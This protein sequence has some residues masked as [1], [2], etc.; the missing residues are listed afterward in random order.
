[1]K[2]HY[3]Q[4]VVASLLLFSLMAITAHSQNK[5]QNNFSKAEIIFDKDGYSPVEIRFSEDAV[6]IKETFFSQYKTFFGLSE[7]YEF[8]QVQELTDKL[9]QTHYRFSQ[10]YKGV[11]V[12][13]AQLILHEKNGVI[14]YINGQTVHRINLSVYP[15]IS[16]Q[17]ALQSA[18]NHIDA[19]I[20][21]WEIPENEIFIKKEQQDPNATFYPSGELKITSGSED[22]NGNNM[23]LV[24][25]FDIYAEQPL[26]RN[27]VDVNAV[28][29][30]VIN[31]INRIHDAD[32]PGT[33]TSLYNGTVS[34]IVD[35]FSGG[36]RLQESGRG[37]GIK[38]YDMQNGY[39]YNNATDFV[40]SDTNFT[41]PNDH[42]GVSVHWAA[43]GTYDYYLNTFGRNSFNNTG[44]TILSYAHFGVD[45]N[46]A[47]WDGTRL[48]FGD[49]DG[50]ILS[51]VVAVDVVGHE[52][53]HGVTQYSSNLIYSSESGALN[54]SFSDIFGT[55]VEFY[56][57]GVSSADWIIGEDVVLQYPFCV[58]S[59]EN[60]NLTLCPD[61]YKGTYWDFYEEVHINSGVQNFWFYLLSVGGT[62]V[63]DN[64]D[65]YSVT[66]IGIDD[67]AEIAY[68]NLT[69]YLTP[70]S[71]YGNAR[72]GSINAAADL[73]GLGSL[74]Y[75]SVIDAWDA[76]GVYSVMADF[77]ANVTGGQPPM[78]VQFT[79]L[80]IASPSTIT[81]WQWDFNEDGIIDATVQ[82]PSWTYTE[83]G[84]Y[85]VSLTVS[86]G[87]S[88]NT[89]TKVDYVIPF[90]AGD[91]LVWE[92]VPDGANYSGAF[93]RDYLMSNNMN[94]IYLTSP[95]IPSPLTGL[96]TVFL[97]FGNAGPGGSL[98][99]QFSDRNAEAIKAYLQIS[100]SRVY[101]EGGVA[102]GL[103]QVSNTVL[104]NLLGLSGAT[105]GSANNTPI[106][107]LSGQTETLTEGMLFTSSNQPN[108]N[109]IDKY[110]PNALGK[111]AFIETTVGNVAVQNEGAYGQKSFCFSY[112]LA[113]LNDSS[114]PN[115]R[116]DL[117]IKILNFFDITVPVE[118]TS[119]T[120]SSSNGN[121]TLNW[122]TA[123]E[124]NNLMFE[125]ER[126]SKD[127]QFITI[128]YVEGK[129][130]TTE[131]QEY[132]Y[133]DKELPAGKYN[134]R[135]KQI[136]FN[137]T[138]EYSNEIEVDA[139]PVSFS[140]E[141]NYPN[142]FNPSTKISY[143][144]PQKSFVTLKVYDQLGSEVAELVQEE[145][146][147]GI[148]K[149]VFNAS[150][151]SSGV[152]FY[153]IRSGNFVETKKMMLM[154]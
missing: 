27:Y 118:L 88:T 148:Y 5:L 85:N 57:E 63:N 127:N 71:K 16:E 145:K 140:L 28:T 105:F 44:G 81:S 135:L 9:G 152:Y 136:D 76:V 49:G 42:A 150:E 102:L 125:I 26:S 70:T 114:F 109:Y 69:V 19:E 45:Y 98:Y 87:T 48:T 38:T 110:I 54:E 56:L 7:D 111:T 116:E 123:T 128:G 112:A 103:D 64:G 55:A 83:T 146:E 89:L 12:V 139:A 117:L 6:V 3:L 50:V 141:Q 22:M 4:F 154:K 39:N 95:D 68:R 134:Y 82:N 66:G 91:I 37:G 131:P 138:Y 25:R 96:N 67:A 142:P 60:P 104:L 115:T 51:P 78:V 84:I 34:M 52:F 144:V 61:T 80:S 133:T 21:K 20:Y 35:N 137:G 92:A 11:E 120:G 130:T 101:L 14:H 106:T 124:T 86:D 121:V 94:V 53:T 77:V 13:N 100:G 79:D 93:I 1:M 32:I 29:G 15:S 17:S 2:K 58:R 40:D 108:N 47:F 62:G 43:E 132:S 36:Y 33:G 151:F 119:F 126:R 90:N 18:L 113:K 143:S 24:Y 72:A 99:T 149:V 153:Q 122:S 8:V 65:P 30:E 75:L 97:S 41:D 74:Q 147:A 73:F 107:N 59:M 129:G 23:K 10:F 46:N 31:T